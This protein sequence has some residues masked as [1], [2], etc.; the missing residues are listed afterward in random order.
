MG[1]GGDSRE[2]ARTIDQPAPH[3]PTALSTCP[4]A[5]DTE[6]LGAGDAPK[7]HFFFYSQGGPCARETNEQASAVRCEQCN[8]RAAHG[9]DDPEEGPSAQT[10]ALSLDG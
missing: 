5:Q 2:Q 10:P 7:M 4:G 6:L 3:L 1:G 8:E 9:H